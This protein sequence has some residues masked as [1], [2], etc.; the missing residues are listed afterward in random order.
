MAI[1]ILG[2]MLANPIFAQNSRKMDVFPVHQQHYLNSNFTIN[3][4]FSSPTPL[5]VIQCDIK[6]NASILQVVGIHKGDAFDGWS[7][8]FAPWLLEVDN[9]N[10]IIKNII[11]Y[12]PNG[13]KNG[14]LV[15]VE[16]KGISTGNSNIQLLNVVAG[17]RN[18]IPVDIIIHDGSVEIVAHPWD[19][20]NDGNVNVL[21]MIVIAQHWMETPE[22]P[23]WYPRADV[24]NDSVVNVL[25]LIIVGQHFG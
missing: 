20:N 19:V 11:A 17:D 5:I 13:T 6:Y 14:T 22:S 4:T 7:G 3:I 15:T 9:E 21:D 18:G 24:N 2:M 23:N 1:F 25:D 12:S 16:F 8:D 10:G